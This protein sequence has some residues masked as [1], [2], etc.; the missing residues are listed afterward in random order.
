MTLQRKFENSVPCCKGNYNQ[1]FH[2]HLYQIVPT[3]HFTY[4]RCCTLLSHD[5]A[6]WIVLAELTAACE[7]PWWGEGQAGDPSAAL[8]LLACWWSELWTESSSIKRTISQ[9][10]TYTLTSYMLQEVMQM[11]YMKAQWSIGLTVPWVRCS[12]VRWLL[13]EKKGH[14]LHLLSMLWFVFFKARSS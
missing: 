5:L 8:E 7:P 10:Y 13:M 12:F 14:S 11:Q 2:T 3:L 9:L 4:L 1:A 6:C